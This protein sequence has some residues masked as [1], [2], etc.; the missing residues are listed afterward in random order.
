MWK[1]QCSGRRRKAGNKV[2]DVTYDS[3]LFQTR[4]AAEGKALSP[5]VDKEREITRL[6]VD[7]ERRRQWDGSSEIR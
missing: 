6:E 7:E 4:A 3:R 5:A 1:R 2:A